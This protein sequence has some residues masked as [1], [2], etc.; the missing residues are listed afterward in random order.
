[1]TV[2]WQLKLNS[3]CFSPVF[4][5]KLICWMN[6]L[7]LLSATVVGLN[8]FVNWLHTGHSCA[9]NN[10]LL[11]CLQCQKQCF[12]LLPGIVSSPFLKLPKLT[13]CVKVHN[14]FIVHPLSTLLEKIRPKRTKFNAQWFN[15]Q[16]Y[17]WQ[18]PCKKGR[19]FICLF[20][21]LGLTHLVHRNTETIP[22]IPK[23]EKRRTCSIVLP[24]NSRLESKI[25][26]FQHRV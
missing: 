11:H 16:S 1:M 4:S 21:V 14:I 12:V 25:V 8:P 24:W 2:P 5:H 22:W 15:P 19:Y 9:N 13:T 10:N 18:G 26:V 6:W 23:K 17:S 20:T 7:D 3:I